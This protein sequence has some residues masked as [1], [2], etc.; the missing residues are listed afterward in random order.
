MNPSAIPQAG[1]GQIIGYTAVGGQNFGVAV[2]GRNTNAF[3]ANLV[4]REPARY[5]DTIQTLTGGSQAL[6]PVY[7]CFA[8]PIGSQNQ[9]LPNNAPN[10]KLQTN[11]TKKN[12]F[13]APRCLLLNSICFQYSPRMTLADIQVVEDSAYIEL[14][15]SEKIFHEGYLRD[16]P[17]GAGISGFTTN[18]GTDIVNN[19]IPA[20][21]YQRT[22]GSWS[23][24]IP[25]LTLFSLNIIFNG[26]NSL[27]AGATVT[28]PTM[29]GP[30]GFYMRILLD[31]ISDLPVQ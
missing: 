12:E 11:M 24:Y 23:K 6:Q 28:P 9:F 1:P 5:W 3:V 2:P 4:D 8:T 22:F 29:T 17:A 18:N 15:I 20:P 10:T 27:G 13:P 16:F 25:P 7:F 30:A 31:G 19:G 14:K 21:C 26:S